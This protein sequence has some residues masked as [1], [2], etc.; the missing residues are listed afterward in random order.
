MHTCHVQYVPPLQAVAATVVILACLPQLAPKSALMKALVSEVSKY[1]VCD[2]IP[3]DRDGSIIRA[4]QRK[5]RYYGMHRHGDITTSTINT[6]KFEPTT[7]GTERGRREQRAVFTS[8]LARG[9]T[10]Y[11]CIKKESDDGV[12]QHRKIGILRLSTRHKRAGESSL[13]LPW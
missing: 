9:K 4:T 12:K 10:E 5:G 11:H 8:H 13:N 7:R 6:I 1:V 2:V 3:D